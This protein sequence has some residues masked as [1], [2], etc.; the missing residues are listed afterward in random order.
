MGRTGARRH[1]SAT[2]PGIARSASALALLSSALAGCQQ[3]VADPVSSA[4]APASAAEASD[5]P[6]APDAGGESP[7]RPL[8]ISFTRDFCLPCQVMAPSVAD[9]RREHAG[10]V[11]VVELNIDRE[12]YERHARF[13]VIDSVPAQV[14]VDSTGAVV[15]RRSGVATRDEL[16]R[17]LRKLRWIR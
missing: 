14:F 15:E 2:S 1:G 8:V 17:V 16:N 10:A 11:D 9:I 4:S 3:E 7:S 13:F 6:I 5:V 12:P